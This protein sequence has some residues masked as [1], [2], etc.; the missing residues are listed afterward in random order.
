M[1]LVKYWENIDINEL[2]IV[3]TDDKSILNTAVCNFSS[4]SQ[5]IDSDEFKRKKNPFHL[6]LV[7]VPYVGNLEKADIYIL[8]LNP[9]FSVLNYYEE[10]ENN[11]MRNILKKN[12]NQDFLDCDFPFFFLNPK[13]LWTGGGQYWSSK[14]E[15]VLQE[16]SL[17]RKYDYSRALFELSNRLAVLELIPY[18]SKS[19]NLKRK[20][21]N[22][23]G[24]K[25]EML[26]YVNNILVQKAKLD[27]AVIII[28]RKVDQWNLPNHTNIIKYGNT[29]ARSAHLTVDSKG[30]AAII[31]RIKRKEFA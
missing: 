26:K 10:Y 20:Y 29:E 30:G 4:Y 23:L 11:E 24:S 8:L 16:M 22:E 31:R 27:N 6:G 28:T 17:I 12:I 18:H 25:R 19:Y 14:L 13:Y 21:E 2:P 7:P 1:N 9:G 15:S 3:H 5:Y